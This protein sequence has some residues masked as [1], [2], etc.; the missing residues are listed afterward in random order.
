MTKDNMPKKRK[1][2]VARRDSALFMLGAIAAGTGRARSAQA[3]D[4][5]T[6]KNRFKRG[7]VDGPFGQVHYI[8]T[9]EGVPVI[10][11][12]QA[13]MTHQ[14]F[15]SVYEPLT[16]LGLR[17]I[18]IDMPG[19]GFSDVTDF[20]PHV[21]DWQKVIPPVMEHLGIEKA[22]VVGHHTGAVV[23]TIF[24]EE[25]PDRVN[26]LVCHGALLV[27]EEEREARLDRVI[28]NEKDAKFDPDG[29]HLIGA[30]RGRKR[31]YGEGADTNL[32]TRYVVERFM[33]NGPAWYGH[34][35]AY[36]YDHGQGLKNVKVPTMVISNSGDMVHDW[37]TRVKDLGADIRFVVMDGGGVDIVDQQPQEWSKIVAEF[38]LQS[39]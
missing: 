8:D 32:I 28:K 4:A 27:T 10:L 35:A 16:A 9:G 23:A 19:F 17:C 11:I 7:Y 30:F 1:F 29:E 38:V 3:A 21:R 37:T 15:N 18:G 13:L 33:G 22:S 20:V 31:M 24:A 12:H 2:A 34:W 25:F 39:A 5:I 36:T 26:K 14:Q 6:P